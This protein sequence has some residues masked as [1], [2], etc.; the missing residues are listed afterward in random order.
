MSLIQIYY[1][2]REGAREQIMT[3]ELSKQVLDVPPEIEASFRQALGEWSSS[4]STEP[5]MTQPYHKDGQDYN[6][7]IEYSMGNDGV[8]QMRVTA[9]GIQGAFVSAQV[10]HIGGFTETEGVDSISDIFS[11]NSGQRSLLTIEDLALILSI[12]AK[13]DR[14][15]AANR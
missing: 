6:I 10:I 14:A 15:Q 3:Q 7:V 13:Y 8:Q 5:R 4:I 2:P 12:D 1:A 11:Q 9:L